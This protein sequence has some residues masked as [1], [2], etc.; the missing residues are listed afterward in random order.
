MPGCVAVSSSAA[1]LV[2]P[3]E[4]TTFPSHTYQT[5]A[6]FP[7]VPVTFLK[8]MLG[9]KSEPVTRIRICPECG[10]PVAEH[11]EWCSIHRIRREREQRGFRANPTEG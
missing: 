7:E 4:G 10:M 3:T 11:K 8:K 5:V 6:R 2:Q 1:E 9:L